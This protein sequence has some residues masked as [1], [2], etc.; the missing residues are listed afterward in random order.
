MSKRAFSAFLLSISVILTAASALAEMSERHSLGLSG[1][2]ATDAEIGNGNFVLLACNS[3]NSLYYSFDFGTTWSSATGGAYNSGVVSSTAIDT[4]GIYIS[5]GD[6]VYKA[7]LPEGG[8]WSPD[9]SEIADQAPNVKLMP[10]GSHF[11][12]LGNSGSDIKVI[13]TESGAQHTIDGPSAQNVRNIA[14]GDSYIFAVTQDGA[15]GAGLYR[16]AF[17]PANGVTTGAW[18][19][20][21]DEFAEGSSFWSVFVGSD[22]RVWVGVRIPAGEFIDALY[23]SDDDGENFAAS[24]VSGVPNAMC[25]KDNVIIMGARVSINN[26]TS[27][28]DPV[29]PNT[30]ADVR[31]ADQV[32]AIDPSDTDRAVLA[33]NRG[34][35]VTENLLSGVTSVWYEAVAGIEGITVY[36]MSQSPTNRD[37]VVLGT[38]AGLAVTDNFTAAA[39]TWV[40]PI[41]PGGDCVGGRNVWVDP[42][43]QNDIYYCSGNIRKV[44]VNTAEGT[45]SYVDFANKPHNFWGITECRTF[46]AYPNRLYAA[47]SRTEGETNGGVYYYDLPGGSMHHVSSTVLDGKPIESLIVLSEDVIF[48]GIGAFADNPSADYRGI[49]R[50]LDGGQTW[51]EM[52]SE[53]LSPTVWVSDFAYDQTNDI[54]YAAAYAGVGA[55]SQSAAIYML[56]GAGG[57]T[58]TWEKTNGDFLDR[59]GQPAAW[60]DFSAVEVDPTNGTVYVSTRQ[61]LY[62]STDFGETWILAYEGL[63]DEDTNVL[64][65]DAPTEEETGLRTSAA[66]ARITQGCDTGLY[67]LSLV[68]GSSLSSPVYALWNGFLGMTNILE[69]VNKGTSELPVTVSIY[70]IAGQQ[71]SQTVIPVPAQGQY[72]LIL[73]Q[74]SGFSPDS[75]GIIKLEF[76]GSSLEGRV[77]FY[78]SAAAQ[79]T[80]EF[81]FAVPFTGVLQGETAVGFNTFQPSRALEDQG[82]AVS[83]WLSIVNLSATEEKT[84]TVRRYLSNGTLLSTSTY[85]VPALQRLDVQA[86]HEDAGPGQVG[87]NVIDPGDDASPYL[88]HLVRYGEKQAVIPGVPSYGFAFPLLAKAGTSA[89]QWVPISS[90]ADGV[91]WLEV[92]NTSAGPAQ[93]NVAF[94]DN[95]GNV[96]NQRVVELAGYAQE[97]ILA[98]GML[99]PGMSGAARISASNGTD[100]IAQSMFY[101]FDSLGHI[102]AMYGSQAGVVSDGSKVGS[103]NLFLGMYSWLRIF[104]VS[105][106]AQQVDLSVFGA[107]GENARVVDLPAHGGI[108]LGLHETANYGTALDSYGIVQLRGNVLAEILR[109]R[110]AGAGIDFAA[111]TL[112]R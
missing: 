46:T 68:S 2:S 88:A 81:A 20:L 97:H 82:N 92:V 75:Y 86:G 25:F 63:R 10:A 99:S 60:L 43:N 107:T 22:E 17:D 66:G 8:A 70:D 41:C 102:D 3:P 16:A 96:L 89:D 80:Y 37:R 1:C 18:T 103:Y 73:N 58:G 15:L 32:C 36:S 83:Q 109:L 47:F 72:D 50:S 100:V 29:E 11:L 91:N 61:Y 33:T 67:A 52:T 84:F 35:A 7:S 39:P 55:E 4:H 42:E 110:P 44:T 59:E 51:E 108:D 94:F 79:S 24:G 48:A 26:G 69:L 53:E 21:S 13:D 98:S 77:S 78:R 90:G 54:L 71:K 57:G 105:D 40:F 104:N 112:V 31:F 28:V 101:F 14:F 34:I 5:T 62:A 85:A 93:V 95:G 30:A 111:P 6:R 65:F 45:Y 38:S 64:A 76:A 19:D 56:S 27:W 9:W 74:V 106:Q 12:L 49:A 87:L 23:V